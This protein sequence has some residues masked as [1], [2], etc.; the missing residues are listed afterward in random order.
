MVANSKVEADNAV[1]DRRSQHL[2]ASVSDRSQIQPARALHPSPGRATPALLL[3][4][5]HFR[6]F[7][8]HSDFTIITKTSSMLDTCG[9]Y[10][11]PMDVNV[12]HD[13]LKS[14]PVG[15]FLIRDSRQKNC[16]FAISVKTARETVSIRIKFYA[17]KFSLDGSKESF[18]CLFQ[19]VEHYMISP[20]KMLVSPLRK[21][22]LRPLQ[23][24]C[25][26]S[27]L[28]TFGRQNLDSIPLNRVLK[29]YL[30]SFPFQI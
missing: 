13:K 19:L 14:E 8:S 10:W 7:R 15:T 22:R 30:K 5:T 17:G 9:F 4:D 2:E 27:I 6:T 26:K 21:V 28:T 29:D 18:S 1:A 3:S 24:L 16:F 12:A 25:R 11:G 20:K 23:E